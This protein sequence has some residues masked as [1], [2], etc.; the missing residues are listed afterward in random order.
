MGDD[1]LGGEHVLLALL[2]PGTMP[3]LEDVSQERART[4]ILAAS[5]G[6][7]VFAREG[8]RPDVRAFLIAVA[9]EARRR[10]SDR[11]TPELL[12]LTALTEPSSASARTLRAI[13]VDPDAVV[14]ALTSTICG[15]ARR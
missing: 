7:N 12:L 1:P 9:G 13:G 8:A 2:R 6:S 15:A 11:I 10:G 4:Q 14:A 5:G 3:A